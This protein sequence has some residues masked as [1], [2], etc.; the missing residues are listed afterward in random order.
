MTDS[1]TILYALIGGIIP[2]IIWLLFWLRED[3][4]QPEP[5]GR[6]IETFIAGMATVMLV[7]PFQKMVA[8]IFPGLG[9]VP[10][11]LW[12]LIE[13]VFKF[14]AA[15]VVALRSIDDNEPL[16]PLVYMIT[17]ALGFVALENTL[18]I[19]NPLIDQDTGIALL[20]GGTRFLGASLLHVVASG[21]IGASIAFSFYKPIKTKIKYVIV[22]MVSAILIHT[23]FNLLIMSSFGNSSMEVFYLVWL[24]VAILLLFFEKIKTIA[25]SNSQD[26]INR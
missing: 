7:I 3:A 2:A 23:A 26:I 4:K 22:G 1:K 16:D 20:T 25:Q 17:A 11:F 19:L 15:Y 13:E 6:I 10:F 12:A 24:C 5:K 14:G 9:F 21:M 8:S 18:F